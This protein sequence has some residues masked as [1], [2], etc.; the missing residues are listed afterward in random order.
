MSWCARQSDF[1]GELAGSVQQS[2]MK[3]HLCALKKFQTCLVEH[4]HQ[5]QVSTK[6]ARQL[7]ST[8]FEY[9]GDKMVSSELLSRKHLQKFRKQKAICN[10]HVNLTLNTIGAGLH[11]LHI[12]KMCEA[13]V[14]Q[15][16]NAKQQFF[17]KQGARISKTLAIHTLWEATQT[18]NKKP[19]KPKNAT[20]LFCFWAASVNT[21]VQFRLTLR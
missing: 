19:S 2:Q 13:T 5:K 15:E 21:R 8:K 6:F 9:S 17:F 7:L 12:P 20:K 16:G 11:E 14:C 4:V 3:R 1:T 18:T 10:T